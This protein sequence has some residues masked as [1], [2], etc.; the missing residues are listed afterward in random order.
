MSP[1]MV[2][3][4]K[5]RLT[6]VLGSVGGPTITPVVIQ[7]L[8]SRLDWQESPE[9]VV[10][11][12]RFMNLNGPTELEKDRFSSDIAEGLE[13]KGQ[14]VKESVIASGL[15]IIAKNPKGGWIGASD[16]RREGVALGD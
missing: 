15:N 9:D 12:G 10:N 2:F 5:G 13:A 7:A 14:Q 11:Q 8:V 1:T 3:D 6:H 4:S 16:P